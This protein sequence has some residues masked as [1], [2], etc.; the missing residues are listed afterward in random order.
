[1]ILDETEH[2]VDA[3]GDKVSVSGSVVGIRRC[4]DVE[5][6]ALDCANIA[7]DT[8]IKSKESD[9]HEAGH[10]GRKESLEVLAERRSGVRE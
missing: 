8:M 5:R 4:Q 3:I 2:G 6:M 7:F 1:M 10:Q 9:D